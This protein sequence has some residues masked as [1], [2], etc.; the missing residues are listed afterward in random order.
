LVIL[1]AVL[2]ELAAAAGGAAA[3]KLDLGNLDPC[4]K[5]SAD[6]I[7]VCG[8]RDGR[9]RYRLPRLPKAYERKPL[10]AETDIAGMH[11]RAHVESNVRPDGL[12]DKRI[13]ITFGIPF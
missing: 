12:V 5:G 9:S 11:A 6:E 10:R 3:V 8:S 4:R 7:V 1:P 13:M 2:L